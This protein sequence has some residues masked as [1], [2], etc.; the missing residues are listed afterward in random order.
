MDTSFDDGGSVNAGDFTLNG[1]GNCCT[2]SNKIDTSPFSFSDS[3][4]GTPYVVGQVNNTGTTFFNITFSSAI[5]SFGAEFESISEF[6]S[7]D[8]TRIT[9]LVAD[10]ESTINIPEISSTGFFGIVGDSSFSTLSFQPGD[11]KF[12]RFGMD[13]VVHSST[14]ASVPFEFSPTLG[15]LAVGG[16]WGVSRL[17]KRMAASK[18]TE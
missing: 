13:N 1:F 7:F 5:T 3:V 12:D 8:G 14:S 18:I 4:N 11:S 9:Q 2:G 15:L 17:R 16:I 10:S 6:N